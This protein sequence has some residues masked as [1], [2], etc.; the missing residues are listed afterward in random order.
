M[1][2]KKLFIKNAIILTAV[3]ILMR[4]VSFSFNVYAANK[5]GASGM[6]LFALIMS[7]YGFGITFATSGIHLA[8]TKVIAEEIA[9]GKSEREAVKKCVVYALFFGSLA[10]LLI[11]FCASFFANII[12]GDSRIE[13]PLKILSISLPCVSVSFAL[14]GYFTASGK[15]YKNSFVQV[16]EQIVKIV[17]AIILLMTL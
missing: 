4:G 11:F 17:S 16:A 5:I 6:G 13:T 10:M 2:K 8:S 7:V 12:V 14:G 9:Q 3:S 1:T 15:V